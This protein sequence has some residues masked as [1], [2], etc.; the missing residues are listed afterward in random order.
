MKNLKNYIEIDAATNKKYNK[1]Y[2]E[3]KIMYTNPEKA[4]PKIIINA[5]YDSY[6]W[7]EMLFDPEKMFHNELM[8]IKQ[9][10]KLED[11]RVLSTRVNFGTAQIAAAFGCDLFFPPNNLPCAKNHI[12]TDINDVYNLKNPEKL[13]GWYKKLFEFTEFYKENLPEHIHI[14]LPDVQGPLN[15]AHL[16]RG[17][18]IL[19]DFFDEPEK[20]KYLLN[21]VTEYLIDQT[22]FLN[23]MIDHEDGWFFDWGALWKGNGRISNCTVHLISPQIYDDYIIECD[24]KFLKGIGGGRMHYCGSY[25]DVFDSFL[26]DDFI[27]GLDFDSSLHSLWDICEITPEN[28]PILTDMGEESD[29]LKRLLAKDWPNKKNI[30]L[31]VYAKSFESGQRLLEELKESRI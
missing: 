8:N 12:L 28:V 19:F 5:P 26:K 25:R 21:F 10:I 16:I 9:H 18:D 31:N 14:Q 22:K 11:D 1:L 27:T 13:A 15:N 24:K 23:E 29:T 7:E 30:I 20:V 6:T 2:D 4:T 3:Y 17:N